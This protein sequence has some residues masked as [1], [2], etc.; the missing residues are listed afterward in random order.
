[1]KQRYNNLIKSF[2]LSIL[3]VFIFSSISAQ[4]TTATLSGTVK[5][6]NN[7]ALSNCN[8]TLE[9]PEAGIKTMVSTRA[10][11]RF[12]ISN[13]R[14]GGPYK[15]SISHATHKE[16]NNDH[17]I[18]TLGTNNIFDFILEEN[19]KKLDLLVIISNKNSFYD[20]KRFGA[21]TS[22]TSRQLKTLPS[23][24]RSTEDFLRMTPSGSSTYNGF[25]IIGRNGQYNNYS[26]DGSIFN[27]P[28]G[29]DAPTPGGQTNAQPVSIDAIEQILVTLAP[30]DVTQ[31]G[32]TGAGINAVTKSG[33]NKTTG[34]VYSYYRNRSMVGKKLNGTTQ[35]LPDLSQFQGGAS[36][37]G[38]I[39]KNKFFYFANIETEQ[40]TD[41]ASAYNAQNSSN[42]GLPSTSR[43]LEQDL[44]DV[45]NILKTRYGYE[46][47]PY[48]GFIIKQ[49]NY[50]WLTKF[51]W[52][53][54]KINKLSFTYNGLQA[55]KDKPAHPTA[56]GRRGPDF[57]TLQFQNS[58][59]QIENKIHSFIAELKS[60]WGSN[61]A[62]K[63]LAVY[64]MF[65]DKRTPFSAPFPVINITKYGSRYIIAGHEPFSIHN[66]LNQNAFQ[67]TDNFNI[68]K[69]SHTITAGLSFES[70]K[71]ENS[72]NLVGYGPSIF[73]EIDIQTFK[74]SV[75]VGGNV[76]FGAYPLDND[77]E[78]ARNRAQADK[79]TFYSLSVAQ[80]SAYIQDEW[81]ADDKFKLSYGLRVDQSYVFNSD[82]Q[83]PNI[84]ADGTFAGNFNQGS[85]TLPNNDNLV[86]FDETGQ[87]I[88]NGIG[89][90]LDNSILPK[91]LLFSP[92]AGFNWDINGNKSIILRGGSGIFTGRFPFIW[93]GNHINYPFT[94]YYNVTGKN[95]KW[96]QV[97]RSDLGLDIKLK[98]GTLISTDLFYTKDLKAMMVRNYNL[99]FPGGILNS[100][101]GD[102]RSI[103]REVDKGSGNTYVFT[104]TK[105]G[106]QFNFTFQ[107]QQIFKNGYSAMVA[108]N[109]LK[110]YDASSIS[111]EISGD[112]F[113]RNPSLGN[114]NVA[115]LTPS[116]YGN[117]HRVMAVVSKKFDY[118]KDNNMSSAI[119]IF[120]NWY[121]GNKYSYVYGGDIN[122]DGANTNDLM[123]VPTDGEINRMNFESFVD[124]NGNPIDAYTQRNAF[125]SFIKQDK[126][127]NSLRGCY[128][129][130][131]AAESPWFSTIDLKLL[132]DFK[133]HNTNNTVE[134]SLDIINIG[135]LLNSNWGVREYASATGYYQPLSVQLNNGNTPV[136]QFDPGLKKTFFE[137]PDLI[138]RW[139]MQFGVRYIF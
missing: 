48:Q 57:T 83:S 110:S 95:F 101:T 75:P 112:A 96:P 98:S 39:I 67:L 38:A 100:G 92:R 97:W 79:W 44:I 71:F 42:I 27:N 131:Y 54:N 21:T 62:N 85:P 41:D 128:T 52:N 47:G 88:S 129:E 118:G 66:T 63:L 61:Y 60:N 73:N 1:M 3:F 59:Y 8:I 11:G 99:G 31:S 81:Q 43:V 49:T 105:E 113:D 25:S 109:Y 7:E 58:G 139:Q 69:N 15:I 104:N 46:T 36:L 135:N 29:L 116:A 102:T 23:I 10:D 24:N 28:F 87:Q 137:N 72:F 122:N 124:V 125:Q 17:I 123:Y 130:K 33:S 64:T 18:L 4:I 14:V 134:L 37:G 34:S 136:Y 19:I 103:Y 20:S 13:L 76:V 94:G 45:S 132:Q 12:T 6:V 35:T 77:V 91:G 22:I 5:G 80:L 84:N 16:A 70:F 120:G 9:Y 114:V 2:S 89:K 56:I 86:L 117:K 78:Y 40:R 51:D 119:S 50:K 53:I 82:Y 126:Y 65:R 26:L 107:L 32:F 121:S 93:I 106:Y 138:S 55:T 108:Y 133:I 90:D 115:R 111:A 74:D 127:L 68:Y 30:Y